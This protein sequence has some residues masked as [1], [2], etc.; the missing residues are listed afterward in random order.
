VAFDAIYCIGLVYALRR[1]RK[2][3]KTSRGNFAPT[4]NHGTVLQ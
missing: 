2:T 1:R 4:G 3:E